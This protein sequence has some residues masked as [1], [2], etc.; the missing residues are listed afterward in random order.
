MVV[1]AVLCHWVTVVEETEGIEDPRKEGFGQETQ[2]V[3]AYFYSG[4]GILASDWSHWIHWVFGVLTEMFEW[5]GLHT[6]MDNM[7]SMLYQPCHAMGG[8][9]TEAYGVSMNG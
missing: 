7:V 8:H 9:Y 1:D 2:K 4:N 3:A 5:V 6:N